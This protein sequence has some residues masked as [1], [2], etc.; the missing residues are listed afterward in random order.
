MSWGEPGMVLEL[1]AFKG[2]AGTMVGVRATAW[3]EARA[4]H[5]ELEPVLN[6]A[7]D[8]LVKALL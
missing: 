8:R 3:G 2:A 4:R 1:K 6:A 7:V 5:D